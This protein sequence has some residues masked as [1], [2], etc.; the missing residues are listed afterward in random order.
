MQKSTNLTAYNDG[1]YNDHKYLSPRLSWLH[2]V[3]SNDH[4]ENDVD[5]TDAGMHDDHDEDDDEDDEH[6]I[7]E[8][9]GD[10]DEEEEEVD[11]DKSCLRGRQFG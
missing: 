7:D 10:A 1:E 5:M 9:E 11:K 6:D 4:R 2:D 3:D 8:D